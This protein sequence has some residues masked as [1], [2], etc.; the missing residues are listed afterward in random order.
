M[1]YTLGGYHDVVTDRHDDDDDDDDDEGMKMTKHDSEG[2][3]K[4]K[5]QRGETTPT[6]GDDRFYEN[7]LDVA[8]GR[9]A[10]RDAGR[11]FPQIDGGAEVPPDLTDDAAY[12]VLLDVVSGTA[13]R[14]QA[15]EDVRQSRRDRAEEWKRHAESM[16]YPPRPQ[17]E[18]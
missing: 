3:R 1:I 8:T 9:A 6:T 18:G 17:Y 5:Q 11:A 4:F 16:G 2:F 14:R 10:E 12:Q 15:Q 7:Y 13:A